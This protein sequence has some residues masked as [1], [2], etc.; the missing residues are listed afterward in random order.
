M[1]RAQQ[2]ERA[3]ALE[4]LHKMLNPGD[5]IYTVLRHVSRSGM[6]RRIDLYKVTNGGPLYLSGLAAR[7]AG[8]PCKGDG[9]VIG[10]CGSDM[11]FELVYNLGRTMFPN[12]WTCTGKKCRSNDHSNGDRNYRKHRHNDGGY[13]FIHRW[14]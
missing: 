7:A 4:T 9:V 13:I 6:S 3:K 1:T 12:G 8:W 14:M 5:T 11:G 10:G 2:E